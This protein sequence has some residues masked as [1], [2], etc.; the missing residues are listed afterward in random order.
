MFKRR[1]PKTYM[2][3][4]ADLIYPRGGWSRAVSY[5]LHRLRR[6]PDPPHRIA[7]GVAVGVFV[8]FTPFFGM[9]F[10]L[11][12]I[13]SRL[14]QGNLF[15]ALLAT[16]FGNPITFPFIAAGSLELGTFLLGMDGHVPLQGLVGAFRHAFVQLLDNVLAL[17]TGA[18]AHWDQLWVFFRGLFLP[19]LVGG[20]IP[21]VVSG[22]IGYYLTV[23]AVSAYQ[24]ARI[25]RLKA[26]YKKRRSVGLSKG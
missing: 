1:N 20:L 8:C 25:K 12:A 5:I 13:L 4:A 18:R 15:A 9:H 22:M 14:L 3:L 10:V 26:R 21:G 2:R 11:A 7:R 23:P 6:L 16:F 19:Y 17:F 24:K